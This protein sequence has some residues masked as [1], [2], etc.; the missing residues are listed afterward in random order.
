MR[1]FCACLTFF[2]K[3]GTWLLQKSGQS[4]VPCMEKFVGNSETAL[5]SVDHDQQ[6]ECPSVPPPSEVHLLST[7]GQEDCAGIYLLFGHYNGSPVLMFWLQVK[8]DSE[9]LAGEWSAVTSVL[10][11]YFYGPL[12]F[13][14]YFPFLRKCKIFYTLVIYLFVRHFK[15]CSQFLP[16]RLLFCNGQSCLLYKY[17]TRTQLTVKVKVPRNSKT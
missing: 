7:S 11:R 6:G 8:E 12:P 14:R 13:I 1:T 5:S 15:F 16:S 4:Q 9:A 2:K 3:M 17:T 10:K